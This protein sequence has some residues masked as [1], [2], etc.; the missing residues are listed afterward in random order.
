MEIRKLRNND[1]T[2]V[3]ELWYDTS[4]LAHDFI[5]TD[6][7]K[8]NKKAMA[9]VYLPNSETYLALQKGDIVGFIA[10]AD[11]YLA[12]I[13]VQTNM[14]GNGIGKKLLN[15]IKR[16]RTTIQLKVYKKNSNSIHFYKKQDFKI[17]SESIEESTNE[18]ELIMEWN[19]QK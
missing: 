1:I 4:V 14:Q 16:K 17:L 3:I 11:N 2:K 8:D 18:I 10:M 15:Y 5:S 9:K 19:K 12:A 7:W 13:F 6:Y